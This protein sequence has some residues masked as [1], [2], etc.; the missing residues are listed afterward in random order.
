MTRRGLA[1]AGALVLGAGFLVTAARAAAGDADRVLALGDAYYETVVQGE[2]VVYATQVGDNRYD[3]RLGDQVVPAARARRFAK[4]HALS[5][6]LARIDRAQLPPDVATS[7]DVLR[8]L[9][10]ARLAFERFPEHVLA[11][12]HMSSL[13]VLVANFGTG[14]AE[15]PLRTVAQYEAYLKRVAAL[16]TWAGQAMAALREGMKAGVVQPKP[17][18]RSLLPQLRTLAAPEPEKNPFYEPVK[19]FPEGFSRGERERLE[20]AYR[21]AVTHRAVPAMRK[22][23]D[24]L[25]T[26]Y[27]PAARDTI[28]MGALPQ[29][30]AWYRAM[31]RDQTTLDM[32]PEAIHALGLREV[33][34]IRGEVEKVAPRLGYEGDPKEFFTWLRNQ[35]RFKPFSEPRQILDAYAAINERIV[36]KLPQLFG[37]MPRAPIVL[38]EEPELTRSTASDHYSL[39]AEDGSRPGIFWAVIQDPRKYG[40][41]SMAALFMHE[42]QPGHHFHMALQQELALPRFRKNTWINAY[43]EG[44]ALYAETL[45]HEMGFYDEPL[46]YAGEL[47]AEIVRAVRLV[48]DT[49]IHAKGWTYDEAIAYYRDN[50]GASED[51]ARRQ[52]ERFVAWPAQALGYK[53]GALRIQEL[54]RRA[55]ERLGDRFKLADFHDVVLGAGSLPLSLLEARVERWIE[56]RRK[57]T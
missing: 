21:A 24:M 57:E 11:V 31:V 52:V 36:V 28:G 53:L 3:D 12:E 41:A 48:V 22:L 40:T 35:E 32:A 23:A 26:E 44:W 34:R 20:R 54:R 55:Q 51:S 39:P 14:Q 16:P 6:E 9:L 5:R 50:V 30:D 13:P 2:P 18:I 43:G 19:H 17:I 45:G 56:N 49:G 4:F 46:S 27:L 25:E 33:A 38:R 29:G 10:D 1:L 47:N 37:R 7:Y 15:Q 8:D 42:G